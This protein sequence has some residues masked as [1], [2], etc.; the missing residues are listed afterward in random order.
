MGI[1]LNKIKTEILFLAKIEKRFLDE[2]FE[3]VLY[4]KSCN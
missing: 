2:S 4:N 1:S 3:N